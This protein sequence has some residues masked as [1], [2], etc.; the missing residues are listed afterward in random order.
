LLLIDACVAHVRMA[1]ELIHERHPETC[2][3]LVGIQ[4]ILIGPLTS[5][6]G[7]HPQSSAT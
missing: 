4:K 5:S 1:I 6:C 7:N 2:G 3:V